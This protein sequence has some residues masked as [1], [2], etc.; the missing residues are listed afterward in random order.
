MKIGIYARVSTEDKE[1]DPERQLIKCRQYCELHH[2]TIIK[3]ISEHYTGDSNPFERDKGKELLNLDIE[4]IVIYS[5]DRLTRQHP[6]KVINMINHLKNRGIKIISITEQAFNMESEFSEI[7]LYIMTWFNNYFLQKLKSDIKSGIEKARLKG[8]QIGRAKT[9]F[10][11]YR[12]LELFKKGYSYGMVA[13]E[14]GVSKTVIYNRFKNPPS[15]NIKPYINKEGVL[16][17]N[18]S[19]TATEYDNKKCPKCGK[20]ALRWRSSFNT[21]KC[22]K[23]RVILSRDYNLVGYE[24]E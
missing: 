5:M 10:N 9:R 13:K 16:I 11:E 4:G 2:H 3:E 6:I 17:T 19:R 8:K 15:K 18:V 20:V 12:A 23:C 21:Y 1:Q 22:S 24:K 14:L 7:I